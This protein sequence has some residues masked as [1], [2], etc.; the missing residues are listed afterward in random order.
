MQM[1]TKVNSPPPAKPCIALPAINMSMLTAAP[2]RV[3]PRKNITAAMSRSG[4]RPQMSL[5]YPHVGVPAASA[6]MY[7]NPT[8]VYAADESKYSDIVGRA[9]LIMVMS[10][11]AR[12]T[13][14]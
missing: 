12:K 13:E 3:L 11:A 7:A 4:L 2:Q 9:V 14:A 8:Q 1:L 6:S 10:S 5:S